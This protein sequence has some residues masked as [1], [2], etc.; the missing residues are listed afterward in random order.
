MKSIVVICALLFSVS[1]YARGGGSSGHAS[2]GGHASASHASEGHAAAGHE[3][4]HESAEASEHESSK[5]EHPSKSSEPVVA[6]QRIPFPVASTHH[7]KARAE[8]NCDKRKDKNC[9]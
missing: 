5:S 6:P 4:A 3:A 7:E 2:S 8:K 1:L 9:K